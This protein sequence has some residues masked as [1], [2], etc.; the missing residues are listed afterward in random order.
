MSVDIITIW[1]SVLDDLKHDSDVNA[2]GV[3][4]WLKP[5]NVGLQ[6]EV[7]V[8]GAM[9]DIFVGQVQNNYLDKIKTLSVKHG[10]GLVTDV[11][12]TAI[13]YAKPK[14]KPVEEVHKKSDKKPKISTQIK[15]SNALNP[16]FTFDVF[17]KG[18][19]NALAYNV[20]YDI[21]KKGAESLH[22][23]LFIYGSSGFGKTHM[24]Q[25]VAH[26]YQKAGRGFCY[27]NSGGFVSQVVQAFRLQKIEEFIKNV[28][29]A[30]LLIIDDVHFVNSTSMKRTADVLL[31]LYDE[32]SQHDNKCIILASDKTPVQMQGF[33]NRFLSRFASGLSVAI[34]PPEMD[35]RVQILEKRAANQQ[36]DLPKDCAIFIAQNM[37]ADVRQLIGALTTVNALAKLEGR[38]DMKL[39]QTALKDQIVARTQSLNAENIK[40]VVAEYYGLSV[41]DLAGKKRTRNI[42]R[43]RQIAMALTRE[44]SKDSYPDIGQA[45]GG[46]DHSTVMHACQTVV[47]L[48]ESDPVFEKDYQS[49]SATLGVI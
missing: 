40:A 26:R 6:G 24:I 12:V 20:C 18:K 28:C 33:S 43:P 30:D 41:K 35:T 4:T 22:N 23:T 8:L 31:S 36:M 3:N 15:E 16:L 39:V 1:Q 29:K 47:E 17:V 11:V 48:R 25:A 46:R 5:L 7:L 2:Q 49:L 45:F 27:F 44:F 38:I 21:A 10:Q 32:F 37:P 42:A 13:D 19:S 34:D 14:A 9:N